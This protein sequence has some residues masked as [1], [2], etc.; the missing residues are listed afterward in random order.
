LLTVAEDK[1]SILTRKRCCP[2]SDPVLSVRPSSRFINEYSIG[3]IILAG[4]YNDI[5]SKIETKKI[6]QSK[7][8]DKPVFISTFISNSLPSLSLYSSINLNSTFF[9][10]QIDTPLELLVPLL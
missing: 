1:N 2:L 8:F 10:I 7:K 4:D 3:Q 6:Y 5:L 9:F